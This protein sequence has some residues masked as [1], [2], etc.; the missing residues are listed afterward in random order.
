MDKLRYETD[1]L[2]MDGAVLFRKREALRR[3]MAAIDQRLSDLRMR[4]SNAAGLY[5][6]SVGHFE[7]ARKSRGLL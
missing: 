7:Q 2:C 1:A 6:L 3:E 4:Y 5:G